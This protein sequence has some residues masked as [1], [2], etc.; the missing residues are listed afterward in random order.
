MSTTSFCYH[1]LGT[2]NFQ[3][4]KTKYQ[5]NVVYIHMEKNHGKQCCSKCK[6]HNVTQKGKKYREIRT[7]P[8]GKKTIILCLHLHRLYCNDCKSMLLETIE[9]ADSKKHYSNK[10]ASWVIDLL[11]Y[12][13][14][15]DVAKITNLSWAQVKDIEKVYLKKKYEQIEVENLRY[16]AIDE[17]Y[18]GQKTGYYTFVTN[19]QTG[20]IVF[21]AEG[22]DEKCLEPFFSKL[23]SRKIKIEAASIDMGK[24]YIAAIMHYLPGTDIV[25]DHFHVVKLI[26]SKLDELRRKAVDEAERLGIPSHKGL[27]WIVLKN[28]ENLTDK[29]RPLLSQ[30]LDLNT[31]LAKAYLL[32]EQFRTFWNLPGEQ[33][34]KQF[35]ATWIE[36]LK[37]IGSPI[38]NSLA[39][40]IKAYSFGLLNYF[41]YRISSGIM[42]G[43]NNKVSTLIKRAYGFRDMEY[44]MLKVKAV[45]ETRYSLVG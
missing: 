17:F 3:Y 2:T 4:L 37:S 13:T 35:L 32:K 11:K 16:I 23:E 1:T 25:F 42:E 33:E 27:R 28:P 6:S 10:L 15:Q 19:L 7:L 5:G 41:K 29:Q 36:E 14:I 40:T 45:H 12:A 24:S 31:P 20:R 9:V 8:I 43:L 22:K 44:F 21:V 38:L 18:T 30:L 34:G 39:R 26:N